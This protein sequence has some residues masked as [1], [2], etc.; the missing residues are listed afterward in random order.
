MKRYVMET[1]PLGPSRKVK[2]VIRKAV[3]DINTLPGE[4]RDRLERLFL[5]KYGVAKESILFANS[6]KE[7][8]FALCRCLRPGKILIVGPALNI[9]R[10]AAKA[11]GAVIE[12][13]CGNEEGC[14]LPDMRALVEKAG[15]SDL[16]FIA[17][18]NRTSGQALSVTALTEVLDALSLKDCVTV[19]DE[20]LIEFTGEEGCIRRANSRSANGRCLGNGAAANSRNIIVLRTTAYYFGLPGLELASAVAGP[21]VIEALHRELQSDPSIPAI[22]AARTALRDRSYRRLTE[23]FMKE[24]KGLLKKA[25]S[26]MPGIVMHDSDTNVFLLNAGGLAE[27]IALKAERAGLAVEPCSDIDGLNDTFLRISV[28]KHDHNLKLI[29]LLERISMGTAEK[30]RSPA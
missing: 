11:S 15:G 13:L 14:S 6:L 12:Y 21:K 25:I 4:G 26:R 19:I 30:K 9:Y 5:S 20:A 22:A 18:P 8:L 23:K 10:E 2:A 29:K 7:L 27:E 24:E 17:N 3:K 1:S 28:M 16:V